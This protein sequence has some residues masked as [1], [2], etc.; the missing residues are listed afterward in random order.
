MYFLF[1]LRFSFPKKITLIIVPS[2]RRWPQALLDQVSRKISQ[3]SQVRRRRMHLP[4]PLF[5]LFS[6]IAI[7]TFSRICLVSSRSSVSVITSSFYF[8]NLFSFFIVLFPIPLPSPFLYFLFPI[9]LKK[10]SLKPPQ[11]RL[12]LRL[13]C[14]L[15]FLYPVSFHFF[16]SFLFKSSNIY[17]CFYF[18]LRKSPLSCSVSSRPW[19]IRCLRYFLNSQFSIFFQLDLFCDLYSFV[20]VEILGV[21]NN[22]SFNKDVIVPAPEIFVTVFN[23]YQ[24]DSYCLNSIPQYLNVS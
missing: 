9:W 15:G 14:N 17:R 2:S 16:I 22:E 19:W 24:V 13:C 6:F 5:K 23:L 10:P 8:T 12:D 18:P 11:Y 3:H 4:R 1:H 7:K 20:Q 21:T